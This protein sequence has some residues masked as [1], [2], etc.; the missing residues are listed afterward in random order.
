M[1]MIHHRPGIQKHSVTFSP[2]LQIYPEMIR[3]PPAVS[4]VRWAHWPV[5]LENRLFQKFS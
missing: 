1:K 2:S 4:R 3:K 5:Q